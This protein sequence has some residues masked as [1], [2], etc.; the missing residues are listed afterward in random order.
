M[1]RTIRRFTR[2]MR[3]LEK[4]SI[5]TE[6]RKM[7]AKSRPPTHLGRAGATTSEV[8]VIA[9]GIAAI[10]NAIASIKISYNTLV[11]SDKSN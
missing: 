6:R 1:S 5:K 11:T 3:H 2:D 10:M 7:L 8:V 9:E 4:E